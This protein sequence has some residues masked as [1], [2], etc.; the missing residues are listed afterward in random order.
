MSAGGGWLPRRSA[1][2]PSRAYADAR[3]SP[4]HSRLEINLDALHQCRWASRVVNAAADG[5][6]VKVRA[7]VLANATHEHEDTE[8]KTGSAM[9][10]RST[11]RLP[12]ESVASA[13]TP[14]CGALVLCLQIPKTTSS[15][16]KSHIYLLCR[17]GHCRANRS[18]HDTGHGVDT[19][20]STSMSSPSNA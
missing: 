11:S 16:P 9:T 13:F 3:T 10:R 17:L 18:A 4:R 6:N 20:V 2:A 12:R 1:D 5:V 7:R 8:T 14:H 19:H 15:P